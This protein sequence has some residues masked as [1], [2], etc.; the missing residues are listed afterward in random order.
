MVNS[1]ILLTKY[2]LVSALTLLT[3]KTISET[4]VQSLGAM[5]W[6]DLGII[7]QVQILAGLSITIA[8]IIVAIVIFRSVWIRDGYA[9]TDKILE[10]KEVALM[11]SHVIA[12]GLLAIFSY[13]T[14]FSPYKHYPEWA[15]WICAAGFVGP[16]IY[17]IINFLKGFKV[18]T[19]AATSVE[20]KH[21]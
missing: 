6:M 1:A 21:N 16:E 9:G 4:Q 15:Y 10:G 3:A 20:E 13:M 5:K 19:I 7:D 8:I 2:S 18:Q 17:L 11:L 12:F 14:T